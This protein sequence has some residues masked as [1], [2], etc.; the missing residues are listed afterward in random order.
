MSET[1]DR[2]RRL[3]AAFTARVE[4]VPADCWSSQSPC[5]DWKARDVV[6]HMLDTS[7]MFLGFIGDK[8]PPGPSVDE[9]PLGAWANARDAMQAALDDPARATKEYD[10]MFGKTTFETSVNQFI[11]ADLVIHAWDVSRA[12]G[13]DERLDP[14]EVH[15]I[16]ELLRPFGDKLRGPGAFGPPVEPPPGADEQTQLLAFLGRAV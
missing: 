5:A 1:A 13:L 6:Q 12:T 9:D 4:A 10:G 11:C 16:F 8:L 3:A 15:R 7:G 14:D 2:Y